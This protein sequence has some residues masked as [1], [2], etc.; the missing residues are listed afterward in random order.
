M[1]AAAQGVLANDTDPDVPPQNLTV[2]QVSVDDSTYLPVPASGVTVAT[3]KGSLSI[4]PDGSFTYTPNANVYGTDSV[5]MYLATDGVANSNP[6]TVTFQI[7]HVNQ[8]PTLTINN[9]AVSANE[10]STATNSG[11]F[12]DIDSANVTISAS[13]GAVTQDSGSSGNW[14][15]S[16]T[17]PDGPATDT[18]TI[19]ANDGNGGVASQT[20]S[21]AV[22]NVPPTWTSLNVVSAAVNDTSQVSGS[23]QD[24]G[25][26]DPHQVKIQWG[27]V[28]P[29]DVV[30]L[31]A[32][33]T[34]FGPI[35]HAY[36]TKGLYQIQAIV[37]DTGPGDTGSDSVLAT[38]TVSPRSTNLSLTADPITY[39]QTETL[40]ATLTD[41][42][43]GLPAKLLDLTLD[44]TDYDSTTDASG[45]A[46]WSIPGLHAGS[47][48]AIV[49]FDG[50][51]DPVYASASAS[52]TFAE[53]SAVPVLGVA[54]APGGTAASDGTY[55][56]T[57]SGSAIS[58]VTATVADVTGQFAASVEGVSP[59]FTY[60]AGSL[61]PDQIAS[62]KPLSGPP[63][64][65]GTYT[66]VVTYAGSPDYS[67]GSAS[68]TFVIGKATAN[69]TVTP[70]GV[71]YD[72][73]A[74]TAT[75]TATGVGGVD[76]SSGLT[77]SGTTHTAAG[78][79]AAD[80]WSF[81][82]GM[83]YNDASGTVSDSI[84]KANAVIAVS[85]Y[86]GVY[87]ALPHGAT[88][89]AVGVESTPANL[90]SELH[91]GASFTDAPGGTAHWTFDGDGNYNPSSGDAAIVIAPANSLSAAGV[92]VSEVG[93]VAFNDVVAVFKYG[94]LSVSSKQF[95]GSINWGDNSG[96]APGVIGGGDGNFC[97]E[98]GHTYAQAGSY[99]I[100]V[101]IT[102]VGG[103]SVIANSTA[104]VTANDNGLLVL[105]SSAKGALNVTGNG[106]VT[107]NG[108][109]AVVV[110][111]SNASAVTITGNG[112]IKAA[113]I[114]VTGGI[115]TTGNGSLTGTVDHEAPTANPL[116]G[117]ALPPTPST[118]Y[119]AVNYA[120]NAAITLNPGTYVGGIRITGNGAVTLNPG[121]YYLKGGGFSVTG[122]GSVTGIGVLLVNAPTKPGDSIN[123]TG[124]GN[125]TLRSSDSF[126]GAYAAY[127]GI[128]VFQDPASSAAVTLTGQGNLN[129]TGMLYAP[130]AKLNL[131]GQ[132]G[133]LVNSDTTSGRASVIVDD[134]AITG[135]GGVTVN[136]S[137]S[138]AGVT[139]ASIAALD[140][141]FAGLA[142]NL[143]LLPEL[144]QAAQAANQNQT[145]L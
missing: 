100:S 72:G 105:D 60:Y 42:G 77:V 96:V 50:S 33:Q 46:T 80:A 118:T 73:N 144:V 119:A 141:Y 34:A 7:S 104:A 58:A 137:T 62:A 20:F 26:L 8:P 139:A 21:L 17:P 14:T 48:L 63:V 54:A 95:T 75:G 38:I 127:N 132:G 88:G 103:A 56:Y 136:I 120:G 81:S 126:T 140:A 87:D 135:N 27:D 22:A 134:V 94:D 89:T 131:T 49:S 115:K 138:P 11:T 66:V 41:Q 47:H 23:F 79:Y 70:Y 101:T 76:L 25:L 129:L 83:D 107:V 114:D 43:V 65:A 4:N 84:A 35:G 106:G 51:Q 78:T 52:A 9:S 29:D 123:L 37:T 97:I 98:G 143:S 45:T 68:L 5:T 116:A 53:S 117:L 99:S 108:G 10:G 36:A 19:T 145:S 92:N 31:S 133:L 40:Y 59:T 18:V 110:D 15:W 124:G 1:V 113:D 91:L 57:Y 86:T 128:T 61:A 69:I 112:S 32:G 24:P 6:A 90:G 111:S 109:G 74:H 82:G 39:G 93:G 3:A 13:E 130:G 102:P 122:N 85:G 44:G 12:A 64:Q 142:S 121:V 30:T 16:Y 28:S 71:T 55:N 2:S 67:S 125:V